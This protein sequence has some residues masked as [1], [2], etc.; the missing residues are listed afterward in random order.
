MTAQ[1]KHCTLQ[2]PRLLYPVPPALA[3]S[4]LYPISPTYAPALSLIRPC[5]YPPTL[6]LPD[7]LTNR[8]AGKLESRQPNKPAMVSGNQPLV[9]SFGA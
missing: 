3:P 9:L 5:I 6:Q 8:K 7:K 4:T 1:C 2:S